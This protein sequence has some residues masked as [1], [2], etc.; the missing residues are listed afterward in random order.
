MAEFTELYEQVLARLKTGG[1]TLE[2][3]L[4]DIEAGKA[5]AIAG[6]QQALIGAGLGGTTV[7]GA[8]P[9]AAEKTAG[10][11]RLR[12]RG[13]AE[14]R[15]MTALMSFAN[16]AEASRQAELN[17]RM[18]AREGELGRIAATGTAQY[19]TAASRGGQQTLGQ[20]MEGF[21]VDRPSG[22]GG[23][24]DQFPA[25]YG[26]GGAVPDWTAGGGGAI[27]STPPPGS[28]QALWE[29]GTWEQSLE[30]ERAR[31]GPEGLYGTQFEE[32]VTAGLPPSARAK[33][34]ISEYLQQH[35]LDP[36]S[37]DPAL[38]GKARTLQ[39]QWANLYM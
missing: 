10:R 21:R 9:L 15:Y 16:L 11:A 18:G 1:K 34:T 4:A 3:D 25:L 36:T 29:A 27:S 19:G 32:T 26:Q 35:G 23:Q 28:P 7:T 30:S 24:A 13:G 37:T 33:P 14:S 17:R 39:K 31:A 38:M 6:G 20:F 5:G 12:A 22:G 8:V 2:A